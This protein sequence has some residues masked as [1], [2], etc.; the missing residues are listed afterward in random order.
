MFE[1]AHCKHNAFIWFCDSFCFKVSPL[2]SSVYISVCALQH[3]TLC[4]LTPTKGNDN[5]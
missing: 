1:E 4:L 2:C 5:D 3:I